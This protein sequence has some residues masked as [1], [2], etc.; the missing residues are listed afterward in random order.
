M[1][2]QS[3]SLFV[4][5]TNF[6]QPDTIGILPHHGYNPE[7]KQPIKALQW[8]KYIFYSERLAISLARNGGEKCIVPY[9]VDVNYE[10]SSGEKVVLEFHGY[11]WHGNRS[12][13]SRSTINP[14][15]QMQMG[16]SMT[17]LQKNKNI[18]KT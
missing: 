16:N 13:Y 17:E 2:Y 12:K 5:R 4:F 14:V 3:L 10:T 15:N 9:R 18:K 8:L 11:F 1:H 7:H 6:L